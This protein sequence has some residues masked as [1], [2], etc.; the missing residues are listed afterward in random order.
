MT[1]PHRRAVPRTVT[2]VPLW[3]LAAD[4]AAAHLPEPDRPDRCANLRCAGEAYPCPPARDAQ[5]ACR[6]ATRPTLLARRRAQVLG[7]ATAAADR[8]AGW[9]R[10]NP[11]SQPQQ[12][13]MLSS[14]AA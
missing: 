12:W 14:Q 9:F 10:P 6:A 1:P 13:H 8:F 5:R 7:P 3:L 2:D 4:V 11:P